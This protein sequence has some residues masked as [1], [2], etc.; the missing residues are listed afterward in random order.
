MSQDTSGAHISHAHSVDSQ[1]AGKLAEASNTVEHQFAKATELR[2]PQP[3][4]TQETE[5]TGSE[6]V[7]EAGPKHNLTPPPSMRRDVDRLAFQSALNRDF[8]QAKARNDRAKVLHE[9]HKQAEL[10]Q[11]RESAYER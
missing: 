10:Q 3:I 7:R 2:Q 11:E 6:M 8:A 5:R 9:R 1:K 4:R